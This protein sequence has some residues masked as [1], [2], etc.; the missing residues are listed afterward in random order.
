[1]GRRTTG[2]A[3]TPG[4]EWKGARVRRV[5]DRLA[6]E[7]RVWGVPCPFCAK[8]IEPGQ[9]WHVD[10][11][12]PRATHPELTW[13]S[14]N[15]RAAHASCNT[16][17]GQNVVIA[18]AKAEAVAATG[19]TADVF[20]G[21][22]GPAK[23]PASSQ[24]LPDCPTIA[25]PDLTR[26]PSDYLRYGWLRP[27]LPVP[28][29]AAWP[30]WQSP[31][32]PDATG[33]Y[34]AEV[35]TWVEQTQ[36]IKLRWWQKWAITRQL[37]HR[38]D[39]SLTWREF[40]ESGPRRI[41]KSWKLRGVALWRMEHGRDRFG[42]PQTLVH[43]GSDVAVC[44][45]IQK[46]A[47]R[48]CEQQGWKVS[49]ANG[50]EAITSPD[51]A[52]WLVRSQD[53]VYGYDICYGMADECWK[54]RPDTVTEGMEPATLERMS[55]Q[56]L[57]T[58]TAHR[59][60]TSLMKSA[61]NEHVD[62]PAGEP[63]KAGSCLLLWG[64]PPGADVSDP[65]VHRAASPYW[66]ADRGAYIAAKYAK[67]LKGET[68]KEADDPDPIEAFKAQYL[69][70]WPRSFRRPPPGEALLTAAELAAVVLPGEELQAL[71]GAVPPASA[72]IEADFADGVSLAVAYRPGSAGSSPPLVVVTDHEDTAAAL[73]HLRALGYPSARRLAVGKSL[74]EDPAISAA[75]WRARPMTMRAVAAG[76][77][78][79]RAVRA[80]QLAH[81][82]GTVLTEQA[83]A[84]RTAPGADGP[85]VVSKGRAD[86]VKAAVWALQG[87]R[88]SGGIKRLVVSSS[89]A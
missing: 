84:M 34:G 69:N 87:A 1:M 72:A 5:R 39:G 7:G 35:V 16:G 37:E 79:A 29:D 46:A 45:Q 27:L 13:D 56:L 59:R 42:E 19:S 52:E 10:H 11:I 88:R 85:R 49:R 68:D 86:A 80:G 76:A 21:S 32:A 89:S 58:S 25:H 17:Q 6:G 83:L 60:A 41:G 9:K 50:K 67:A 14:T 15:W 74:A 53:G 62:T 40:I 73:A 78:L 47:W 26:P 51:E 24:S 8:P 36:G 18:K 44:R 75:R 55:A 81:D 82:G 65:K 70:I 20:S 54:V 77:E 23:S 57:L 48:W 61:I 43:T 38:A 33:S 28:D 4:G 2:T 66:S 30:L 71:Q 63:L 64:A 3:I 12:K 31:P 22:R